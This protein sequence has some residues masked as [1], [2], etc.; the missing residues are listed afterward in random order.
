[1][2]EAQ[3][4]RG[5]LR[6]N[7]GSHF[8]LGVNYWPRRSAMWMWKELDLGEVREDMAHI[9]ALGFDV[10]RFFALTEDF[11]PAAMIVDAD[12][13]AALVEVARIA[14]DAGLRSIPTLV[15][16]NMSGRFWWPVW[17]MER[18]LYADPL[19]LRSQALLV[20]RIAGALA[21]DASIR[22][23]D[24]SNEIDDAQIPSSR[25]DGWLWARLLADRVRAAAPGVPVQFGAH[26][27]SLET[28]DH[29][30]IDDLAEVVDEDC[31][32]AYPFCSALTADL[33]GRDRRPLMHEFGLC[34]APPGQP[35]RTIT[36]DFLGRPLPQYLAS[37]EEGARYYQEVLERLVATGAAG[38]YAWCY[39]DYHPR[40]FDRPP[41][42]SAL[43]ERSFGLVR[44]DGSEKPACAVWRSFAGRQASS[45][46]PRRALDVSADEYYED[47]AAHV[48]RLYRRWCLEA[49]G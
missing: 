9:R 28:A 24:L 6:T 35:G 21:G 15:T 22:A 14:A 48:R 46:P 27:P 47:P 40:L 41:L 30:R 23:F 49:A 37:E 1:V 10:V 5:S 18:D 12:R 42:A 38:A 29:M 25:H 19:L 32:H 43:R 2:S 8:E 31:M 3:R 16:I 36:D 4:A 45:Q 34:T 33:A 13:V 26:M 39:G 17:M 44:A 20:G 7:G 11:L